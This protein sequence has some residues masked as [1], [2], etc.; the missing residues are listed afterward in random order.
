MTRL[1]E[2]TISIQ[3]IDTLNVYLKED[4]PPSIDAEKITDFK[5]K[6]PY[7]KKSR[8]EQLIHI[9]N[10]SSRVISI[11]AGIALFVLMV[12][13]LFEIR[14]IGVIQISNLLKV[15]SISFIGSIFSIGG[16]KLI[17]LEANLRKQKKLLEKIK[18]QV[19]PIATFKGSLN[20]SRGWQHFLFSR[21]NLLLIYGHE[22]EAKLYKYDLS[23][24]NFDCIW[25][26]GD[27][28]NI[29]THFAQSAARYK[30]KIFAL[31][32]YSTGAITIWD[33][34]SNTQHA[35]APQKT[36]IGHLEFSLDGRFLA[37]VCGHGSNSR[38]YIF[39]LLSRELRPA[40]GSGPVSWVDD[41]RIILLRDKNIIVY[42]V[43]DESEDILYESPSLKINHITTDG[44]FVAYAESDNNVSNIYCGEL[45]NFS[46]ESF[47]RVNCDLDHLDLINRNFIIPTSWD[48]K[49]SEGFKLKI[50]GLDGELI[51]EFIYDSGY[52]H[53]YRKYSTLK[54]EKLSFFSVIGRNG[55]IP[56][57]N[58]NDGIK[59][60]VRVREHSNLAISIDR[61]VS[62]QL[63]EK[64]S[65]I[66]FLSLLSH[67]GN[68]ALFEIQS[69]L[70]QSDL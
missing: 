37:I 22:C 57:I 67:E 52:G 6:E 60:E 23:A 44:Q 61:W 66:L 14:Q 69:D 39:R 42:D 3:K 36:Y 18:P 29:P 2:T 51:R 7:K 10:I 46:P 8:S 16:L 9:L 24:F 50:I 53:G 11:T 35:V 27:G 26:Y 48:R 4:S 33:L 20:L 47:M 19:E 56:I 21:H 1:Q 13:I 5:I 12:L 64:E 58:I 65:G 25:S 70:N 34:E 28:V 40:R 62:V 63:N 68:F 55:I 41:R 17:S 59:N 49:T 30:D 43:I 38:V 15:I 31:G 54:L 32:D 45:N